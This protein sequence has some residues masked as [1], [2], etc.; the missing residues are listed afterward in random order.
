MYLFP[1]AANYLGGDIISGLTAA[2]L[3]ESEE[4]SVFIDI[5]TNGELV[6]GNSEFLLAGAGAAGPALEGGISLYGMRADAGAVDRVRIEEGR[7]KIHTIGEGR[8]RGIC[9]SGIVD[10]LAELFLNGWVDSLGRL[11]EGVSKR[12]IT[13]KNHLDE[14]QT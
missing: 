11:N 7:L 5:G 3:D 14:E 8:P 13:V 12:I 9:G 6:A 4:L 2:K 10:L 1:A